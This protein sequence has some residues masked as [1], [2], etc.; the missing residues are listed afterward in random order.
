MV[1]TFFSRFVSWMK[2]YEE[3]F[4]RWASNYENDYNNAMHVIFHTPTF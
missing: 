2:N 3:K 1:N 4:V